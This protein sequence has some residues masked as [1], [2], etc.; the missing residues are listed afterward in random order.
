MGR[1]RVPKE[2]IGPGETI[3]HVISSD[4]ILDAA[5]A[6]YGRHRRCHAQRPR[7]LSPT[8]FGVAGPSSRGCLSTLGGLVR[9]FS[10]GATARISWHS[11]QGGSVRWGQSKYAR[12]SF[13]AVGEWVKNWARRNRCDDDTVESRITANISRL[14][15]SNC[16][17]N[18]DM[19]LYTVSR[20]GHSWP[21]GKPLPEW[22]VG[23]TNNEINASSV[24][25]DFF[26]HHPRV[27]K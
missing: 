18:A 2:S 23:R 13:S 15:Y 10:A 1:V 12:A 16:A 20:G 19:I 4:P 25:W 21:G 6:A 22:L 8:P 9:R 11:R 7:S 14:A 24:M 3:L 5:R 27:L 17:D 26:V